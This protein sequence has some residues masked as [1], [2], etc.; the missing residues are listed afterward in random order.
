MAVDVNGG[1]GFDCAISQVTEAEGYEYAW[2][3]AS[4]NGG[5]TRGTLAP[6]AV[7][8]VGPF[9]DDNIGDLASPTGICLILRAPVCSK[10]STTPTVRIT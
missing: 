7:N 4:Q 1:D 3:A 9:Y 10:I 6:G 5:L 2:F 8:N